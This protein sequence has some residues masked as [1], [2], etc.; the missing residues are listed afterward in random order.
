[1]DKASENIETEVECV[2]YH[3]YKQR[4]DNS[5]HCAN[6]PLRA[7]QRHCSEIVEDLAYNASCKHQSHNTRIRQDI[8]EPP[9]GLV[10]DLTYRCCDL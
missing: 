10:I 9:C 2:P 1:M 6:G 5:D 7:L 8:S 3:K 4:G